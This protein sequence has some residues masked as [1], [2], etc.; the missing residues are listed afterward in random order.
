MITADKVFKGTTQVSKIYQGQNLVWEQPITKYIKWQPTTYI[1]SSG[2]YSKSLSGKRSDS[3]KLLI[4]GYTR[5]DITI[6][7]S[8]SGNQE[9]H[10]IKAYNLDSTSSVNSEINMNT[11]SS[12]TITYTIPDDGAEHSIYFSCYGGYYG[13][14]TGTFHI[15]YSNA[16]SAYI[17]WNNPSRVNG[18]VYSWRIPN[19]EVGTKTDFFTLKGTKKV[20]ITAYIYTK[21]EDGDYPSLT[22]TC[23]K[24][25]STEILKTLEINNSTGNSNTATFDILGEGVVN[26]QVQH[27][28]WDV[29]NTLKLTVNSIE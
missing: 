11:S 20:N 23:F 16:S 1:S 22:F 26:F 21:M 14:Y 6:S 12:K 13:A 7:Y 28:N 4:K 5:I 9:D 3:V 10:Y 24:P 29:N 25:N 18:N 15:S 8:V 19:V 27:Y 2:S 17:K